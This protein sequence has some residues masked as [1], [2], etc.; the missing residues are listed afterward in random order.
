M[1]YAIIVTYNPNISLLQRQYDA[2][3]S[4]VDGLVYVENGSNNKEEIITFQRNIERNSSNVFF[5]YNKKNLGLGAAQNQGID[6]ALYRSIDHVVFFDQDSTPEDGFIDKMLSEES[7]LLDEGKKVAVLAPTA[8]E[9]CSNIV[10]PI[11]VTENLFS[12][13]QIRPTDGNYSVLW[14]MASGSLFRTEVFR[15]IG[16]MNPHFFVDVID[17]EWGYR[18]KAKGY[19]V[20]VTA[21]TFLL[22]NVGDFSKS[23]GGRTMHIHQP[24]RL[25]YN[26]RNNIVQIYNP[27][28]KGYKFVI[29]TR[30]FAR[31]LV[32]IF[33]HAILVKDGWKYVKYGFQGIMDGFM[34][35]LGPYGHTYQ[36]NFG[37]DD[38]YVSGVIQKVSDKINYPSKK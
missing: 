11:T 32:R 14:V 9:E 20:F 30:T 36:Y 19:E 2:L 7:T 1:V 12:R 8:I 22:H 35:K 29:L 24:Y 26:T 18:A 27:A 38:W 6:F 17:R 15:T 4:Q 37:K 34:R 21:Q 10:C 25:Y 3:Q 5:I 33:L 28:Y 16:G 31:I 23:V 13:K